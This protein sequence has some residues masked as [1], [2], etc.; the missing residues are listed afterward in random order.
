MDVIM[1]GNHM[2]SA[3]IQQKLLV[4]WSLFFLVC[5]WPEGRGH[6]WPI[7][8][9]SKAGILCLPVQSLRAGLR[10]RSRPAVL[11]KDGCRKGIPGGQGS[12]WKETLQW[13]LGSVLCRGTWVW[14]LAI[15]NKI[16]QLGDGA[17]GGAEKRSPFVFCTYTLAL[18]ALLWESF[19]VLHI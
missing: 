11:G 12:P 7:Y 6:T 19:K 13:Y 18:P 2:K 3:H 5:E 17:G 8:V 15:L 10:Q 9:V 4:S 14:M 16:L 1:L